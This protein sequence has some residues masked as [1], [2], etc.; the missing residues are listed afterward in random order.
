MKRPCQNKCTGWYGLAVVVALVGHL[1][2][3]APAPKT[4]PE[5]R[6]AIGTR[7]RGLAMSDLIGL[8]GEASEFVAAAARS[9][10]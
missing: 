1:G 2:K 10:E 6:P 5:N 4:G 8:D 3:L 7:G 9:N